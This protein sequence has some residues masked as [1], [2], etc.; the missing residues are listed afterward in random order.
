MKKISEG[1]V[2]EI[3]QDSARIRASKHG[4][5]KS[6]GL[7]AGEDA[8]IVEAK[9]L[10]GAKVGQHV[11]FEVE[12][13]NMLKAAFIVYILPLI[14]IFA[15]ALLGTWLGNYIGYFQR[16]FQI[17]GGAVLFIISLFYVKVFDK[18]TAKNDALKPVIRRVLF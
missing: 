13:R 1:I 3:E 2:I 5:C 17:G 9:N 12:E 11:L 16:A 7:C 18:S 15:G 14:A 6:C 4:N 10:V 8:T